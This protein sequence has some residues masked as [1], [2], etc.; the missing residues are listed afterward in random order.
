MQSIKS[1]RISSFVD[2]LFLFILNNCFS[3]C[4]SNLSAF[5]SSTDL[6][7][8]GPNITVIFIP[9]VLNCSNPVLQFYNYQHTCKK[10][11]GKLVPYLLKVKVGQ[12]YHMICNVGT[13]LHITKANCVGQKNQRKQTAN[14]IVKHLRISG[15]G[16]AG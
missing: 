13:C 3:F 6:H 16:E 7:N 9:G 11:N 12:I 14:I 4:T 10:K 15:Q 5:D 1:F 2:F 8:F